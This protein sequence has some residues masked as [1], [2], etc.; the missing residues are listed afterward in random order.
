MSRRFGKS[1]T[2]EWPRH[3]NAFFGKLVAPGPLANLLDLPWILALEMGP[4][5]L[6]PLLLPRRVWR[7]VW[8]DAG[9]RWLLLSA[10]VAIAGYTTVRSYF[11]YNDFGQKIMLV[12]LAAGVLVAALIVGP[13]SRRATWWNPCGWTLIDQTPT[14]PR[15]GVA[16]FV[17]AVLILGA[18]LGLFQS[19]LLAARRYLAQFGPFRMLATPETKRAALEGAADR[20]MRYELPPDTVLQ[21]FTGAERLDLAQIAR[22]QLGIMELDRDTMVFFPKNEEAHRRALEEIS[23]VLEQPVSAARC[24]RVL[25][26][27]RITHVFVGTLERQQWRGLEKF[28]DRL[29]FECVFQAGQTAVFALRP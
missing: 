26:A 12:A 23:E 1:L 25:Q 7:R 4:L 8:D 10:A 2:M 11:T 3:G 5:L 13:E 20:F 17:G 28:S 22:K 18:P 15:R 9:L 24:H 14:R 16:W 29:C 27:H 19:P 6:F 21:G